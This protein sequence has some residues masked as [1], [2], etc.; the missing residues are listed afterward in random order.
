[1]LAFVATQLEG[2]HFSPLLQFPRRIVSDMLC[3]MYRVRSYGD[4]H[5]VE[6]LLL[7]CCVCVAVS[8]GDLR[9]M[10]SYVIGA[11]GSARIDRPVRDRDPRHGLQDETVDH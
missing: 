5:D 11:L 6:S 3:M 10:A 4:K 9:L 8:D 7:P 2:I 1:M